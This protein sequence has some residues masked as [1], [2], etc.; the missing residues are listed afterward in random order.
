MT[1]LFSFTISS[2][3]SSNSFTSHVALRYLPL[4]HGRF[5]DVSQVRNPP[6]R[7][8]SSVSSIFF[9]VVVVR[10]MV[11]LRAWMKGREEGNR[12]GG[13][14]PLDQMSPFCVSW[15]RFVPSVRTPPLRRRSC[16]KKSEKKNPIP[17]KKRKLPNENKTTT[18][19]NSQDV[20]QKPAPHPSPH[21]PDEYVP[22]TDS[23]PFYSNCTTRASNSNVTNDSLSM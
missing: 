9:F 3:L 7:V 16:Y 12:V 14:V 19:T 22:P 4:N 13:N 17:Q 1:N 10:K 2:F 15:C 20:P 18:T 23:F 11:G 5:S 21:D 8:S 6:Q